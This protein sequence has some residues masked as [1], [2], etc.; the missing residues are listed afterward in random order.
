VT[1]PEVVAVT[2]NTRP[3]VKTSRWPWKEVAIGE[4]AEAGKHAYSIRIIG[5]P[6]RTAYLLKPGDRASTKT[7]FAEIQNH[8]A[9]QP[10]PSPNRF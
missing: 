4:I 3:G 10:N 7:V 1:K 8:L 6:G 2:G 5:R 9:A